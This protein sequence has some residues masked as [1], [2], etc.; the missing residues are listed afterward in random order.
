MIIPLHVFSH[1]LSLQR[2][3]D[4]I[5]CLEFNMLTTSEVEKVELGL[6]K[7]DVMWWAN[8]I[9]FGFFGYIV[10]KG[11]LLDRGKV[12]GLS[13]LRTLFCFLLGNQY[14]Y[15]GDLLAGSL[16][17]EEYKYIYYKYEPHIRKKKIALNYRFMK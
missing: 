14:I 7:Y 13:V 17:W 11:K 6:L 9:G 3:I 15:M 1:D 5:E 2:R 12:H 8:R 4:A 16:L 10:Y